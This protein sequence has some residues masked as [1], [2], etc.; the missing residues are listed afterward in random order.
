MPIDRRRYPANW[1]EI[2]QAVRRAAGFQCESC[3]VK[4]GA[5]R[6]SVRNNLYREKIGVA[7]LGVM[8]EDGTPGDKSDT[9]DCREINLAALCMRC[10]LNFDR[11]DNIRKQRENRLKRRW[12]A[13]LEAGQQVLF[14]T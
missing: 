4:A 12:E 13:A 6:I 2:S 9:M 8:R 14:T 1:N 10:H 7:H 3:Q 5:M 11:V